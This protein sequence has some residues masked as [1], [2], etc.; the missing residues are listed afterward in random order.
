MMLLWAVPGISAG[1]RSAMIEMRLC[2]EG[3]SRDLC[4][5]KVGTDQLEV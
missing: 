2:R 5:N 3:V 1:L 4:V